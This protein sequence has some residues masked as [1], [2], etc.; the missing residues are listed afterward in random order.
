MKIP[1]QARFFHKVCMGKML[2]TSPSLAERPFTAAAA[3]TVLIA[4]NNGAYNGG[5]GNYVLIQHPND[6]YTLYAHMIT[7]SISVS[8]GESVAQGD[9]IGKTGMTGDATG[10]HV[11]FEIRGAKNLFALCSLGSTVPEYGCAD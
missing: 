9:I 10:P 5:Y 2:L 7:G 3:G 8:V 11:H 1:S 4:R 6:T